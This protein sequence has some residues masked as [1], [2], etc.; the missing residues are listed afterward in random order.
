MSEYIIK[1]V[2]PKNGIM[3]DVHEEVLGRRCY[4]VSAKVGDS[5]L[6]KYLPDYD[7]RYHSLRTSA[8]VTVDDRTHDGETVIE[9]VNTIYRLLEIKLS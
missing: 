9:T 2:T 7:D 8:I 4:I 5:G 3:R 6:L 1:D